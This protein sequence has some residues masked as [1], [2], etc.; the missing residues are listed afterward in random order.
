VCL[1]NLKTGDAKMGEIKSAREIAMERINKLGEPSENEKL[2]WKYTPEGEKIAAKYLKNDA[3]MEEELSKYEGTAAEHVKNSVFN[4]LIKNITLPKNEGA[5]RTNSLSMQGIKQIKQDKQLTGQ[6]MDQINQI[7][8]H[9]NGTGEQQRNQ[10]YENLKH[11]FLQKVQQALQAQGSSLNGVNIDI[12]RQPQFQE[13]WR[14][15]QGQL[16]AQ[17]ENLL[18]QYKQQLKTIS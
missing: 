14:K 17:Y 13:E 1:I 16:D 7:F 10:A 4:V 11:E 15:L 6:V 9:Y 8:E 5:I 3:N 12:E 2:A 18:E